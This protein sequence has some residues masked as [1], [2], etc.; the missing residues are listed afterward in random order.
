MFDDG[1]IV[2]RQAF[3]ATPMATRRALRGLRAALER[4]A[5]APELMGRVE[6][7]IAEVLNNVA[8][9]AGAGLTIPVVCLVTE[10]CGGGVRVT[11]SDSGRSMTGGTPPAGTLP[12]R[13]V[14]RENLP[15]GGFGWY[16]IRAQ[17]DA[18]GYSRE[19]GKNNLKLHF[20]QRE[21]G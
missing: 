19:D 15:E 3:P 9:H 17:A 11:V 6:L 4:V 1:K 8:E 20:R 2:L 5:V 13:N 21:T 7:V 12:E 18:V 16:L 10:L 14:P